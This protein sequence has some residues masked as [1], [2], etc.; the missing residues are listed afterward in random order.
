MYLTKFVLF[1]VVVSASLAAC[2]AQKNDQHSVEYFNQNPDKR[3]AYMNNCKDGNVNKGCQN[4]EHSYVAN[5]AK[6]KVLLIK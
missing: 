6:G 2:G 3:T 4:A 1:M 5:F